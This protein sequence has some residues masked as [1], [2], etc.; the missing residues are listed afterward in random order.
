MEFREL[1]TIILGSAPPQEEGIF[2]DTE[3][4]FP[5]RDRTDTENRPG[6]KRICDTIPE[7]IRQMRRLYQYGRESLEAKAEN[8]YRQGRFM[9]FYEDD[10]PWTG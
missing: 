5:D 7:P 10:V 2:H 1:Y 9:E 4:P 3:L 8:F 6:D